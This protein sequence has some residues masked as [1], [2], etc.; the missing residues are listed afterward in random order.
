M[1]LI[2]SMNMME[3]IITA[4]S[5]KI[6]YEVI[7]CPAC[8]AVQVAEAVES[9]P[10]W[11]YVHNCQEC[12]YTI[13]ESE[14][15]VA[16]ECKIY[17]SGK[18]TGLPQQEAIDNFKRVEIKLL[19]EGYHV[20]NP[21]RNGLPEGTKWNVHMKADIKMMMDCHLV[22]MLDNWRSS[23]GAQ[24]EKELAESLGYKIIYQ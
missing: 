2:G 24:I 9:W 22:Y 20:L 21:I 23:K 13:T 4:M 3:L 8:N 17:L 18:I 15:D 6:K 14:W 16:E 1:H 11:G 10:W 7:K 19:H 12:N 5:K